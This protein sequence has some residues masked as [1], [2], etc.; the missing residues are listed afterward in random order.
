MRH[1]PTLSTGHDCRNRDT[2]AGTATPCNCRENT[3]RDLYRCAH[4]Q[5]NRIRV[6]PINVPQDGISAR[7]DQ[8]KTFAMWLMDEEHLEDHLMFVTSVIL[9]VSL[10]MVLTF[11]WL[12]ADLELAGLP[13]LLAGLVAILLAVQS[14]TWMSLALYS[15][16]LYPKA[17]FNWKTASRSSLE[18]R[19]RRRR[20]Q[21]RRL[22]RRDSASD[23]RSNSTGTPTP[24]AVDADEPDVIQGAVGTEARS[25][26]SRGARAYD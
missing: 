11:A 3:N 24:P 10:V 9:N 13:W 22:S 4:I 1:R 26:R 5:I 23:R 8:D 17:Y 15:L 2:E 20:R 25:S 19:R 18:S 6:G 12:E 7:R 21:R 16:W 14:C